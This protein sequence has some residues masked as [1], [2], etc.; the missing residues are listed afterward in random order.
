MNKYGL[1]GKKLIH[2]L[3]PFIHGKLFQL[4]GRQSVY[5]LIECNSI[6]DFMAIQGDYD[7]YNVTIPYKEDVFAITNVSDDAKRFGA[8]NC[9]DNSNNISYNTDIYGFTK[10]VE[11]IYDSEY[12]NILLVGFGGVAKVIARKYEK[13]NLTIAIRN[14]SEDKAS[15]IKLFMKSDSVVVKDINELNEADSFDLM[16]N[17]T[18]VGMFPNIGIS[19]INQ[20]VVAR[21]KAVYDTIYNPL[22]TELLRIAKSY[23]IPCKCGL[24]MLVEQAVKS[25]WHWYGAV[26]DRRDIN[27]IIKECYDKLRSK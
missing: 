16:I 9:V 12:G 26:F 17:A 1:L 11:S 21:C 3:S 2:S 20:S 19:P 13:A 4:Q 8:V 23:Q 10:S 14:C 24:D 27:T 15:N 22:E 6:S 5:D 18:P 25:H 7:G